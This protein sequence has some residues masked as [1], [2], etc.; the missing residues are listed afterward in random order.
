MKIESLNTVSFDPVRGGRIGAGSEAIA[1]ASSTR[2]KQVTQ[3]KK[4]LQKESWISE[5]IINKETEDIKKG[6]EE[7]NSQLSTMNRS[8]RFSV[9]DSTNDVVV[10]VVDKESGEVIKEL[11]PE[12]ILKL[13]ER[14]A[15]L[16]GLMVEEKL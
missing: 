10:R 9:D 15:Q 3:S 1:Q 12:S 4:V 7:I 13:R 8:I 2:D 6:I 14:M 16:S 11:P 5:E